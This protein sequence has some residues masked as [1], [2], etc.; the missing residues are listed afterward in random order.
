MLIDLFPIY[1]EVK[2]GCMPPRVSCCAVRV[3]WEYLA[4]LCVLM[5]QV[6]YAHGKESCNAGQDYELYEDS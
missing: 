5:N 3:L 4:Y 1:H 2:H 6:R